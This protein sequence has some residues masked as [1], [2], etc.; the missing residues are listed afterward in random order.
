MAG[1]ANPAGA[2]QCCSLMPSSTTLISR[3]RNFW[4]L[5]LMVIGKS[6][7]NLMCRG[8]LK[9]TMRPLQNSRSA[10]AS[11]GR[12]AAIA[13]MRE[14]LAPFAKGDSVPLPGAIWIVT[15]RA[16]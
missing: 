14:A 12:A 3:M 6:S 4:T 9:W 13:S 16:S 10:S 2:G 8:V 1:R 15:A 7:T 11:T 5:P